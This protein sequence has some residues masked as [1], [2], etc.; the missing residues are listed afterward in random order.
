MGNDD[1]LTIPKWD[2]SDRPREKF[3]E[4]G[5]SALSDAELLAILLRTGSTHESAL[6][7]AKRI[8]S[9]NENSINKLAEKSI[10]DLTKI[11]GIGIVKA[12]TLQT[13]FELGLRRRAEKVEKKK[14]ITTSL[15]ILEIM[16]TKLTSLTHEE[17]WA[18]YLNQAANVMQISNIGKGGLTATTVDIRLIMKIAI[19]HSSTAII[20]CHNHPSGDVRPSQADIKL[21]QQIKEAAE[22]F[23]I[24]ILDHLIVH[25]DNYYS[26]FAEGLLN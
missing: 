7:L 25:K 19:E 4:K 12:I 8:L 3:L 20:L 6:D 9:S 1:K 23:S 15:D 16:Q 5:H 22:L 14:K 26:F 18:I 2:K 17:F 11:N 24:R 13:A 21:T 10:A